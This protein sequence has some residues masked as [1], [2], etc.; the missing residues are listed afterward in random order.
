MDLND[1]LKYGNIGVVLISIV[2]IAVS[3]LWFGFLYWGLDNIQSG[4]EGTDCTIEGNGLW[5]TCQEM[6][7]TALYPFLEMREILVWLSFLFIFTLVLAMLLLGYQS[8][9]NPAMLGLLAAFELLL[10]YASLYVGNIF[11]VFISNETI[12]DMLV[13]F[14]VYN[15]IMMNFPWF[16]FIVSLFSIALGLVNWQRTRVN[17]STS[18]LDY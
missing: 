2:L 1:M 14:S 17:T 3:G 11:R 10:T 4:F 12:R 16:V 15:K 6:W 18:D 7:E 13:E 9:F 5:S 8:G